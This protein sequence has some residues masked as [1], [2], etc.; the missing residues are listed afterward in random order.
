MYK[1]CKVKK[2][3]KCIFEENENYYID[4]KISEISFKDEIS[5]I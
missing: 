5:N 2:I 1:F 4:K 3:S